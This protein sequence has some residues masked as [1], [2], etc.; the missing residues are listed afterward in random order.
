MSTGEAAASRGSSATAKAPF[1][2]GRLCLAADVIYAAL[3]KCDDVEAMRM[4]IDRR[5]KKEE[6][7]LL[8]VEG[9]EER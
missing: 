4:R 7:E 8:E 6:G 1:M 2:L 5:K 3:V 9:W